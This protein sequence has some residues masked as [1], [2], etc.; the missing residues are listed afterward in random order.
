MSYYDERPSDDNRDFYRPLSEVQKRKG[1]EWVDET[2]QTLQQ[3][4]GYG[5]MAPR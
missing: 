4:T 5:P 3:T 1:R 2:R